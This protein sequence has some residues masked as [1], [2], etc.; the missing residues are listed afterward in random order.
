ME[1]GGPGDEERCGSLAASSSSSRLPGKGTISISGISG[2][3]SRE[4]LRLA[5]LLDL[6][7]FCKRCELRRTVVLALLGVDKV[8]WATRA[9]EVFFNRAPSELE[10]RNLLALSE[11]V[12][13]TGAEELLLIVIWER[14]PEETEM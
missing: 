12:R 10:L 11:A 6:G 3:L 14:E 5:G 4:N 1:D 7:P 2:S 13:T 8:D 9:F